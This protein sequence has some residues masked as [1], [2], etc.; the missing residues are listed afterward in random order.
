MK[1]TSLFSLHH[2][3]HLPENAENAFESYLRQQ[4]LRAEELR[5]MLIIAVFS[6]VL[7]VVTGFY[8]MLPRQFDE[9]FNHRLHLGHAWFFF[10]GIIAYEFISKMVIHKAI[11]DNSR[12]VTWMR[13]GQVIEETT[14]PTIGIWLMGY[15]IDPVGALLGPATYMYFIFLVLSILRLDFKMSLLSGF[16][17]GMQYLG[18]S[19]YSIHQPSAESYPYAMTN[20]FHHLDKSAILACT[21]FLTGLIAREINKRI[22]LSF[23][24]VEERN[25]VVNMFGQHVSPQ[26]VNQLLQQKTDVNSEMRHVCVMFLD[27][28]QFTRFSEAHSPEEVVVY[29]N[30]LFG[31]MIEIINRHKG[32]INKFLGDGFMAIFG[33]PLADGEES[34]NAV[35]AALEIC[36]TI[37]TLIQE[38]KIQ[39]TRIGIGL[40]T[41]NAITGNIGSQTRKEYTVIGDTVNLASRIEQLNKQ[42]NSQILISESVWEKIMHVESMVSL[43]EVPIRGRNQQIQLYQLG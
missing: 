4:L 12:W 20:I 8:L 41:G 19:W 38:G 43:G 34:Q 36:R 21:G 37:E 39:P 42:F 16:L 13:Y 22:W 6:L 40:H 30:T 10:G 5:T 32:I 1:H 25:R 28:R 11:E 29:L 33:A 23:N 27:I 3:S 7:I 9:L 24:S 31:F 18:I 14:I 15:I 26:V 17:S 2:T 35:N